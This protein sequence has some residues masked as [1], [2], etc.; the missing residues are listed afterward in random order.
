[1]QAITEEMDSAFATGQITERTE[2][3]VKYIELKIWENFLSK[4]DFKTYDKHFKVV[5]LF[6]NNR[7]NVR[8]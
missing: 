4:S 2:G 8:E 3:L 5:L 6:G 1:M 7:L